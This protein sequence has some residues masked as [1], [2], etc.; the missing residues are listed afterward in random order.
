LGS[1]EIESAREKLMPL[2][3]NEVLESFDNI[4]DI[5]DEEFENAITQRLRQQIYDMIGSLV[6]AGASILDI[7]CGTGI[8]AIA[9]AQKG[10]TVCGTDL[11]P[12]M[13]DRARRKAVQAG[14]AA[15]FIVSSFEHL[16][17]I[18]SSFDLVLSNFGGLNCVERLDKA[19]E[20]TAARIKPGGYLVCVVMPRICLWETLVGLSHMD[21][22]SAFRRLKKNVTATGFR[23]KTFSV[24]Y[25]SPRKFG[26][27]FGSWFAVHDIRG[28]NILSP[29]PHAVRFS[30]RH[31]RLSSFL[32]TIDSAIAGLPACRSIGDHYLMTLRRR[33]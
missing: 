15:R 2:P 5:F 10:Y 28:L 20:Q 12:K 17:G 16:E 1:Q 30:D 27:A 26:N 24:H 6:P 13:V 3:K 29:P 7:N 14:V 4:A 32:E 8:D 11:A 19:A 23:G 25:H 31:P 9:L 21:W 22:N 33:P 18:D